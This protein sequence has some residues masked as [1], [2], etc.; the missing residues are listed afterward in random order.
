M[1]P[2]YRYIIIGTL[3]VLLVLGVYL[4]LRNLS[5]P[6]APQAPA[7]GSQGASSTLPVLPN[8]PSGPAGTNASSSVGAATGGAASAIGVNLAK[9][10]DT[11]AFAYWV[12]HDTGEV[13]YMT[14][15]GAVWSAKSGPDIDVSDQAI[16]TLDAVAVAPGGRKVLASFGDPNAP[17]WGIF[18]VIDKAWRPLPA[19][20]ENAAWGADDT[21]LVATVRNGPSTPLSFVDLTKTPP[22]YKTIIGDFNLQDVRFKFE[23]PQNLFI[24]EKATYAYPARVWLLNTKTLDF[25]LVVQPQK[26]LW[27]G[28][29]RSGA[30]AFLFSPGSNT[31]SFADRNLGGQERIPLI[32]FPGKCD[33][34]ASTT[35][36]FV[37]NNIAWERP[38]SV[39]LPDDYLEKKLYTVDDLETFSTSTKEVGL[40]F[41]APLSG[42]QSVDAADPEIA[43]TTLYFLN[44]Y[45]G[46]VYSIHLPDQGSGA[47]A[48]SA[49]SSSVGY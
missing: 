23:A 19:E 26:G 15:D 4:L 45:D 18:D 2:I 32:T 10:S 40:V 20:I 12:L 25:N 43:G 33:S 8:T 34:A 6:A 13:Y 38:A 47:G 3:A 21:Q 24:V 7:A 9:L 27:V 14:A 28:W 1:K 30:G 17:Q 35:Y 29:D 39:M 44:R 22:A 36:C 5:A 46:Y 31:L 41:G 37:P 49:A 48:P 16:G 42:I 11:P